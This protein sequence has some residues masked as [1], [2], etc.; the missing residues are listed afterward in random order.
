MSMRVF[1]W[2]ANPAVDPRL[3]KLSDERA[4]SLVEEG[5]GQFIILLCGRRAVQLF[6]SEEVLQ[7]RSARNNLIPF[8][9]VFN[10][11]MAPPSINY[12][13]PA[14]GARN[15]ILHVAQVNALA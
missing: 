14:C 4:E 11:L 13:I 12:P 10:K 1:A 5:D 15:R 6:P 2:D 9:R 8:G 3:Y 7:E